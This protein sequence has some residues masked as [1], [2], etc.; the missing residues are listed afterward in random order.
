[1]GGP[2][3]RKKYHD[4]DVH[5][6]RGWR[7]K[8]RT[9]DLDQVETDLST[10]HVEKLVAQKVDLEKPG[11]GQFYCV[12]CAKHT[13]S[14]H[15]FAGH[16]RS[17]PHKRRMNALRTQAYTIEESERAAGLGSYHK[18]EKRAQETLLP[19]AFQELREL[20][21]DQGDQER[22]TSTKKQKR[23]REKTLPK[24][25]EELQGDSEPGTKKQKIE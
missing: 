13:I 16:I 5:L 23:K 9:K 14:A 6:K 12:H 17:K 7:T 11:Q 21:G 3:K 1:M 19:K 25:F 2:Y 4:G 15:A 10:G 22:E 8:N 20:Q 24:P 18:P